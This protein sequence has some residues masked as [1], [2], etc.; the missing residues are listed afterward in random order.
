MG[1]T[2]AMPMSSTTHIPIERI[3]RLAE[4]GTPDDLKHVPRDQLTEANRDGNTPLHRA[5]RCGNCPVIKHLLEKIPNVDVET[6]VRATNNMGYTPLLCAAWAG[7]VE[8]MCL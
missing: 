5:A 4:K 7:N 8:A 2:K 1:T 3:L 6:S